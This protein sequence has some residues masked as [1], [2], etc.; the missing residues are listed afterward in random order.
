MSSKQ[1]DEQNI[2]LTLF[3]ARK[4]NRYDISLLLMTSEKLI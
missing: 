2:Y 4:G 3:G 1:E